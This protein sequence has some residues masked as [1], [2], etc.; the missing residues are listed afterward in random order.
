M[1]E[2]SDDYVGSISSESFEV[3][4]IDHLSDPENFFKAVNIDALESFLNVASDEETDAI[5]A[6]VDLD[7]RDKSEADRVGGS[8]RSQFIQD[9]ANL[10]V[11]L[12]ENMEGE[13]SFCTRGCLQH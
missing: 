2:T 4:V 11:I 6:M 1:S 12:S 10:A 5:A 9:V 7:I 13:C 3:W 8:L